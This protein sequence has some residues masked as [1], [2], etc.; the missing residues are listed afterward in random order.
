MTIRLNK[1]LA[2]SL[3]VSRREADDLIVA[4]KILVDEKPAVVGLRIERGV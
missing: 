3:G 2:E 1:F 4:G